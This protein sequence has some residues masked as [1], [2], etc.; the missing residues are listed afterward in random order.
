MG[1]FTDDIH[2]PP[3]AERG[4]PKVLQ[5]FNQGL[6]ASWITIDT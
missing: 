2:R 6:E 4:G 3:T 5:R 1:T